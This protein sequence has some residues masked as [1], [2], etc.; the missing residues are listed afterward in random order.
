MDDDGYLYISDR[1]VDMIV[2]GGANVYPAEVEAALDEH[3]KILSAIVVGLPDDDLGQRIH[4][5]VQ[6]DA[7]VTPE[8]LT[9]F[10]K[11]RLVWYKLPRSF[12]FVD[13]ALRDDAG[14]ARRSAIREQE[15]AH[16]AE[17]ITE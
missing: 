12:R 7:D 1:R 5:V 10:M 6:A 3:P 11:E 8:E 2:T 17:Q 4:A 16:L 9:T 15:I 14:K 13:Y